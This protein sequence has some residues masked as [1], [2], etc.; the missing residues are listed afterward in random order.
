MIQ[1]FDLFII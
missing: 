1:Y